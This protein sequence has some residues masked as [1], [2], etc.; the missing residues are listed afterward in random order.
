MALAEAHRALGNEDRALLELRAAHSALERIGARSKAQEAARACGI[1]DPAVPPSAASSAAARNVF[2]AEGDTRSV[3]YDGHTVLL[4]DLKGMRYLA[5]L[6][7]EPGREFHVLDLVA[8]ERGA[9]VV[10]TPSRGVPAP[11]TSEGDVGPAVDAQAKEAY[12]RRLRD[13]E[14]DIEEAMLMGD[15]ERAALAEADRDYIVRELS[16]AFGLGGRDRHIGSSSERAR[17]SVTRALRYA[18]DRVAA[19]HPVLA[20]HLEHTV[21]TGTYCSYAPDPRVP[22]RWTV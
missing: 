17:A 15:G 18:L 10:P 7:A 11:M 22:I 12:R 21:R 13:I 20:E 2:R 9:P 19:H 14:D 1:G 8:A 3:S 5:R 6:L 16:R 4:G